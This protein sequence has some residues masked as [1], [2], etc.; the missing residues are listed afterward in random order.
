MLIYKCVFVNEKFESP[1]KLSL[2]RIENQ[3][4]FYVMQQ[5]LL[6]NV[7]YIKI[8]IRYL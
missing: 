7:I 2:H 6:R 3:F 8:S 4:Y 1:L 5:I